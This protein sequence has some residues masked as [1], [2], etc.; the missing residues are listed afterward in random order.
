MLDDLFIKNLPTID[1]HGYDRLTAR[2]LLMD[3]IKDCYKLKE[4]RIVIIHGKG[5][6]V[7]KEEIT[8]VLKKNK[9]IKDFKSQVFN[10]GCTIAELNLN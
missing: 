1:L 6:F 4:K 7:L 2:I 8:K 9:Y 5:T 3:F 10:A